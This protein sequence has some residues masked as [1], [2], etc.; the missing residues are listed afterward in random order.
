MLVQM[1][2]DKRSR[3]ALPTVLHDRLMLFLRY[4]LFLGGMPAVVQHYIDHRD[5]KA[6]RKLQSEILMAYERDFS[7]HTTPSTA[8]RISEIWRSLP[9]QLARENKKFRYADVRKG[10]RASRFESAIEWLRQGGLVH[11]LHRCKVPKLP[12]AGYMDESSFKL[13]MLD[14]GLLGAM[15]DISSRTIVMGNSL[16][17]EYGGAFIE[18]HAVTELIKEGMGDLF[19]WTSQGQAEVDLIVK[20]EDVIVPIEVK[21]GMSR[22]AKSLR[23]Y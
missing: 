3:G 12:L 14:S 22:H 4:F 23:L 1:L 16:F 20:L 19:Y 18:N 9:S 10:G 8:I 7:K 13:Y 2:D 17:S 6:V 21:S 5:V 15:L 11:S